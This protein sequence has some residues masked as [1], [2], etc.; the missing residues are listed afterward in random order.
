MIIHL[1]KSDINTKGSVEK[2]LH[3][4]GFN[5]LFKSGAISEISPDIELKS[6]STVLQGVKIKVEENGTS[7]ASVT[8]GTME[9]SNIYMFR[10]I[11]TL[12]VLSCL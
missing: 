9:T 2:Y 6:L 3:E 12:T 11:Y 7:L 8:L 5:E 10:K 1:P 4:T